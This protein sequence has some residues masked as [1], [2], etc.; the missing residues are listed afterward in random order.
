MQTQMNTALNKVITLNQD[1]INQDI[2][3][4]F[5]N[6]FKSAET[7][8]SYSQTL[9]VFFKVNHLEHITIDMVKEIGILNIENFINEMVDKGASSNTIRNRISTLNSFY[10]YTMAINNDVKINPFGNEVVK[11]HMFLNLDKNDVDSGRALSKEEVE[12]LLDMVKQ[13]NKQ[14]EYLLIK[15]LLNFGLR[16]SE[17]IN[18]RMNDFN[19]DEMIG[20]YYLTIVKAKG[21]KARSIKVNTE[22]MKLLKD[23]FDKRGEFGVSN[24]LL[25]PMTADNVSKILKKWCKKVEIEDVSPHTLRKTC[26]TQ[27]LMNKAPIEVVQRFVGH[28]NINTTI[29]RYYKPLQSKIENGGDYVNF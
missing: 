29:E 14:S 16:R 11:E 28:S 13:G 17:M 4:R 27:M 25:F 7:K 6:R 2:G 5:I 26:V 20:C 9:K 18:V 23:Y 8:R 22:L 19:Y 3:G 10:K 1:K 12:K 21:R 24:D 15:C